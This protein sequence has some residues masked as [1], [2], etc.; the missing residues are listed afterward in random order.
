[1]SFQRGYWDNLGIHL[2]QYSPDLWRYGPCFQR[3]YWDKLG[4]HLTQE[5]MVPDWHHSWAACP[6]FC[7]RT[8]SECSGQGLKNIYYLQL[9]THCELCV[10][11]LCVCCVKGAQSQE[12]SSLSTIYCSEYLSWCS[13]AL[14]TRTPHC[15]YCVKGAQHTIV[16]LATYHLQPSPSAPWCI[17]CGPS[18]MSFRS[19]Y[20]P[21]V[22]EEALVCTTLQS[23]CLVFVLIWLSP[24]K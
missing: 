18:R 10:H 8:A 4:I 13:L 24:F 16:C 11:T 20:S 17:L 21:W 23:C 5:D 7:Y 3:G 19:W 9:R 15:S 2:T 6:P 22:L 1:M 12:P 14:S